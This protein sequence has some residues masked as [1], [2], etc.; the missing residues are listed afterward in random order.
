MIVEEDNCIVV[1]ASSLERDI[2]CKLTSKSGLKTIIIDASRASHLLN[3]L[4]VNSTPVYI[5]QKNRRVVDIR[6]GHIDIGTL[7]SWSKLQV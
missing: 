1:I 5:L 6:V 7:E 2:V 4:N 3:E